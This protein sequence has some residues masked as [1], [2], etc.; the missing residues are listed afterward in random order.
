VQNAVHYVDLS[1]ETPWERDIIFEFD[2]AA[3]K[4]GAIIVPGCGFDSVPSDLS[5][6]LANKTIMA[7]LE[8]AGHQDFTGNGSSIKDSISAFQVKSGISGGTLNSFFTML[9][10][11]DR[12]KIRYSALPYALSPVVGASIP[13]FQGSYELTIPGEKTFVGGYWLM[14]GANTAIVQRTFGLLET[15]ALEE[16]IMRPPRST[17]VV[18][19]ARKQRYGPKFKYDEFMVMPS[20]LQALL[21]SYVFAFGMML[22]AYVAPIRRLLRKYL[23]QPG[24]GPSDEEMKNGHFTATNLTTSATNPPIQAKT[25]IKLKGDPGYLLTSIMISESALT[26]LLPP[27]SSD[28]KDGNLFSHPHSAAVGAERRCSDARDCLW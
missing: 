1:G 25:V 26:L 17:S 21:F 3:T 27:V 6:Y 11:V 23:P 7:A 12:A 4:T 13:R 24:E 2:Y 8:E 18:T 15:Q 5:A 22:V 28:S 19:Q 14:R 9:E 10:E 20:A 16:E